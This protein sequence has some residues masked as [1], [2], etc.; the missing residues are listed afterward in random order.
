MFKEALGVLG[1]DPKAYGL[2]SLRSGGITS[3]VSND[4]SK[5]VSER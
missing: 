4:D 5:I 2:H 3:D 1:C